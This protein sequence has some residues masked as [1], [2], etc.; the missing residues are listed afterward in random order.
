MQEALTFFEF[1]QA[2]VFV[3]INP[4]TDCG[5]ED[6]AATGKGRPQAFIL[7]EADPDSVRK[8]DTAI[9]EL[10]AENGFAPGSIKLIP[11]AETAPAVENAG[12][13]LASSPRIIAAVFNAKGFLKD[14]GAPDIGESDQL[15]YARSKIAVACRV[16]GI[17]ALD[18][19]FLNVKDADG[20]AADA[21][22]AKALG[23]S[24]KVAASGNQVP[25]INEIFA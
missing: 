7:P 20:L 13:L 18:G 23:F 19:A 15:L 8:A 25:V 11:V 16:A 5:A 6:I 14:M 12:E 17:P 10:E 1:G 21:A 24:A 2:R 3:R 4:M 9:A 22:R